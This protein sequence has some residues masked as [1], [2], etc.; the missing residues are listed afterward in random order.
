VKFGLLIKIKN[1]IK[2]LFQKDRIICVDYLC[3]QNGKLVMSGWVVNKS[4]P[5]DPNIDLYSDSGKLNA[6]LYSFERIDVF[7]KY[8]LVQSDYCFGFFLTVSVDS[9]PLNDLTLVWEGRKFTLAKMRYEEVASVAK[10]LSQVPVSVEIKNSG[11]PTLLQQSKGNA[12][13]SFTQN[14]KNKDKDIQ[15]I[16]DILN[17]VNSDSPNFVNQLEKN[18]IPLIHKIWKKRIANYS[19]ARVI[20]F[21]D[22]N[23]VA[24]VSIIVPLYGRYDF[25][26]HQIAHFS[27]D[28][29]MSGVELVYVLD[30][31][32]LIQEVTVSAGGLFKTF[33]YPFKLV[34]S[35]NNRGFSGAN[36]LG[37]EYCSSPL[38]LFLNSD[39]IPFS[40][41]WLSEFIDQYE[42]IKVPTILGATL[43]YEDQTIQHMGMHFQP[44]D[45]HSEIRMNHHPYKGL[46]FDLV[47]KDDMFSVQAVTG[48]C[49]LM[50]KSLFEQVRGFDEMHILGDFE[51][52]DLCLKVVDLGGEIFCS[53]K[54]KLY[55][56]ER[57][58]QNLVAKGDWK[59]KLSMTNGAYQESKWRSLIDKVVS[60]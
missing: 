18:T 43:L 33:K 54:V 13:S 9:E 36:N 31:P 52:S 42:R 59:W 15:K 4:R 25:M 6:D 38:V 53:N 2:L 17:H 7:Q 14:S 56:L 16:T 12:V 40:S 10:V 47:D 8:Q 44:E 34:L 48:A 3:H 41:G 20:K 23:A 19:G 35:E 1:R 5:A 58:S 49:M 51:D 28:K 50:A 45:R 55:H 30:D 57:L 39:V 22:I 27:G 11:L 26:Q 21:G 29:D 46:H 37:V 24:R 32:S 60:R